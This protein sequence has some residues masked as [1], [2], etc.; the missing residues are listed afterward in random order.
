MAR[1]GSVA[2]AAAS[3]AIAEV[4]ALVEQVTAGRLD[5][6]A[7]P[8]RYAGPEA[9]LVGGVN[10]M[11]D[12]LVTPLR[13]AASA[14]DQIAHGTIP[15]FIID[16]YQGEFNDIKRN[17]N[18]FLA[19]MY[20]MHREMEHLVRA[21]KDGKLNTRG[22][23]WDFQG[24]WQKMIAGVNEAVDAFARPFQEAET[25]IDRLADGDL[26]ERI[27]ERHRGDFNRIKRS[28][29][30]LQA[31]LRSFTAEMA[32]M[33]GA[34]KVGDIDARIPEQRFQG[35][36]REMAG[37]V[38]DG[39]AIH[40]GVILKI[41]D[42]V[43]SYAE[44]EF[45]PVLEPLPGKQAV[46]TE[47]I[48][49]LRQNLQTVVAELSAL[50]TSAVDGHLDQR[51]DA[52][53]F[54]G[55]WRD[56]VTGVNRTLDAVIDPIK[57]ASRVLGDLSTYD[58]R[59]R[60][61]GDY[62]GD[63]AQI[64]AA[65]NATAGALQTAL[66][67][68][69]RSVARVSDAGSRIAASGQQVAT[70]AS[71][72][73]A[74]L[75]STSSTLERI[76]TLSS[77]NTERTEEV[78]VAAQQARVAVDSG[79][80]A[81]TQMV[82]AMGHIR[83]SAQAT[84]SIIHEINTI[85]GKTDTLAADAAV[86]AGHV[87]EASRGFAVVAQEVRRLAERSKEAAL[88]IEAVSAGAGGAAADAKGGAM[89]ALGGEIE[90]IALQTNMLALN[91]AVEA[92]HVE[93]SGHGFKVMSEQVRDLAQ[94]AREAGAKTEQLIQRSI[95]QSE[96]GEAASAEIDRRLV[97]IANAVAKVTRLAEEVTTASHEQ[98][99]GID[100]ARRAV[101]SISAVTGQNVQHGHESASAAAALADEARALEGIVSRF[102][103]DDAGTKDE[104]A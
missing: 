41:L 67:E 72:Q 42:I 75:E 20:G 45:S 90:R 71:E 51:V 47:K 101:Q 68:V 23:D 69:Q 78:R 13:D 54:K 65:L 59:A 26:P 50:S 102:R 7:D 60:M 9:E 66:L 103:L 62:R 32:T 27:T 73:A 11:L 74:S 17:V 14:I 28:L 87:G 85:G 95:A 84:V 39:M 35:I 4:L 2:K 1:K 57:E 76:A 61:R 43:T 30:E 99:A 86:Q 53:K 81:A 5:V 89:N 48:T 96:D 58:L 55:D 37:G 3:P 98:A 77:H 38:N 56:L 104:A 8:S 92:A 6:R 40:I 15:E 64:K 31:N 79:N 49:L 12:A 22:N 80:E 82:A 63:H 29:N 70:G 33:T 24:N 94:R 46:A 97:E 18:T 100:A 88:Q 83:E 52:S 36:Y 21:I 91:A 16:D 10:R 25:Y 44:G 93:S 19:T 34:H